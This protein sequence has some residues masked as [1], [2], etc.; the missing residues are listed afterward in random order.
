MAGVPAKAW[1]AMLGS[2][3][4]LGLDNSTISNMI[5]KTAADELY[6]KM[7]LLDLRMSINLISSNL[8][9][10]LFNAAFVTNPIFHGSSNA[11]TPSIQGV[12]R[13]CNFATIFG[14]IKPTS[15]ASST[16]Y[17]I[18]IE[19]KDHFASIFYDTGIAAIISAPTTDQVHFSLNIPGP[20]P[21][22]WRVRVTE[23]GGSWVQMHAA[24]RAGLM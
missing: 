8:S 1:G 14:A 4:A 2:V 5:S 16:Q 19:F 12:P 11:P 3:D 20:L 13:R 10:E 9:S 24:L 18:S 17:R 7:I 23:S 22:Q 15:A 21:I 6:E